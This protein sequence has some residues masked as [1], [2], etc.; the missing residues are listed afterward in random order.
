MPSAD[1]SELEAALDPALEAQGLLARLRFTR[2]AIPSWMAN[3][4]L[5]GDLRI[6]R[7]SIDQ[8]NLGPFSS[9]FVWQGTN[10][11]FASVQLNLP[12]GLIRAHGS[13]N[14]ASYTPRCRLDAKVTG[15]PWDGGLLNA[16]GHLETSGVNGDSL[17]NLHA[18][19]KFAANG[20]SLSADDEFDKVSGLFDF[21]FAGDWPKLQIS[22]LLATREDGDWNGTASSESD[23][24]LLIDLEHDGQQLHLVSSLVPENSLARPSLT[25]S[26]APQ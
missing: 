5:E 23:G 1:L 20:I 17:H 2:R 16:E 4:N 3:R 24:K 10:L 15:F 9:H 7:F 13:L 18:A 25:S 14:L 22:D 12:E 6:D 19:G 21:S 11:Q 8:D 26:T